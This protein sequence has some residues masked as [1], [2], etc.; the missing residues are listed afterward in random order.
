MMIDASFTSYGI[1][2]ALAEINRRN[3]SYA[4]A[5]QRLAETMKPARLS[6]LQD[7]GFPPLNDEPKPL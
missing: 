7:N 4:E 3:Q 2:A 5:E 6:P 1:A